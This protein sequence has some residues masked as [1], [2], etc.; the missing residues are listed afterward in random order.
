MIEQILAMMFQW[1]TDHIYSALHS[2]REH[3]LLKPEG[4]V[5]ESQ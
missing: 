3:D 5:S 1:W 4:L 2:Y